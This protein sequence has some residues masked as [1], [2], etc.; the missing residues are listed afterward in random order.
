MLI[1][2]NADIC[3]WVQIGQ[4]STVVVESMNAYF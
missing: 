3:G 4:N 1:A 2:Q